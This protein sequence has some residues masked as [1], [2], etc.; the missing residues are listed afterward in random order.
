MKERRKNLICAGF[1]AIAAAN[2]RIHYQE[3]YLD[4]IFRWLMHLPMFQ[5][6]HG[7]Y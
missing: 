3:E 4:I 7:K 1:M 5:Y 6:M 2:A